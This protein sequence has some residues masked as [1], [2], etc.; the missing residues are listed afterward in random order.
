MAELT[1]DF[2]TSFQCVVLTEC[3][4]AVQLEVNG[5][6]RTTT[7]PVPFITTDVR[8]LFGCVFCDFGEGF[9]VADA[10]GESPREVLLSSV[11]NAERGEVATLEGRMHGLE[12]GDFVVFREVGRSLSNELLICFIITF[13]CNDVYTHDR[14]DVSHAHKL[15]VR[16][17]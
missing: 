16:S 5:W 9:E 3:S 6:C 11:T 7:P 2:V 13:C 8:G 4:L 12:D 1:R 14:C 10:T 15:Q 17:H